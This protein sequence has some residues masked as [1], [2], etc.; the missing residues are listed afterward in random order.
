MVTLG[1]LLDDHH[2]RSYAAIRNAYVTVTLPDLDGS[3]YLR[4]L[5]VDAT[6][7]DKPALAFEPSEQFVYTRDDNRFEAVMAY[8]FLDRSQNFIQSLGFGTV[9]PGANNEPQDVQVDHYKFDNSFYSPHKDRISYGTG[10]V[11][12]AEDA[13][14]ILH[15]YGHAIQ[16]AEV[17]G[18]G[19]TE[20]GGAMGEGFGDYWAGDQTYDATVAAGGRSRLHRR[21]GLDLVLAA[22]GLPAPARRHEALPRGHAVRG[23]RRR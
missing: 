16:D 4:G 2:D 8:Y 17:P 15:E 7:R 19:A 10:G 18:W 5:W 6:I 22:A 14:V 12:D 9:M 21:L 23:A 1:R 11:D 20:E 3:G 13:D